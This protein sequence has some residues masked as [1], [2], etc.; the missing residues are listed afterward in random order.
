MGRLCE[1]V[2]RGI[3]QKLRNGVWPSKAP[4]GYL[5]EPKLRTIVPD[6]DKSKV[7][8]KAFGMFVAG[9]TLTEIAKFMHSHGIGRK[10]SLPPKLDEI[11]F[12]LSNRFYVGIMH[13]K[14]EY[15]PASHECFIPKD[16]FQKVQKQLELVT[17]KYKR[18]RFIYCGLAKCGECG[19]SITAELKHKKTRSYIYYRCTKK[20]TDCS[21]N[22]LREELLEQQLR[23]IVEKANLPASWAKLWLKKLDKEEIEEKSN[24]KS[25]V[26]KFSSENSGN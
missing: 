17:R 13:Y 24:S 7:V 14:K 20:K 18:Q 26:A 22:Y 2:K 4:Y 8:K 12:M 11:S 23:A 9:A 15:Y 1:N 5:N 3:R 19:A 25:Q 6:P 21:Q 10:N 16:L